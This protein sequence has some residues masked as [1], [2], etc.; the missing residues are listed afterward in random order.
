MGSQIKPGVLVSMSAMRCAL[1]AEGGWSVGQKDP[2]AP[3]AHA[4]ARL[5]LGRFRGHARG[6]RGRR[7]CR[8][9]TRRRPRSL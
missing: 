1:S 3:S 4:A 8:R 9:C 6:R 5:P 2:I 7:Y